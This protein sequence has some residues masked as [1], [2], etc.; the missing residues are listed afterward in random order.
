[1][2]VYDLFDELSVAACAF[3]PV[4]ESLTPSSP[5]EG[6]QYALP[7]QIWAPFALTYPRGL[8]GPYIDPMEDDH[9]TEGMA[10]GGA[11]NN[12]FARPVLA[13]GAATSSYDATDVV[14]THILHCLHPFAD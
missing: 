11:S 14:V 5:P 4:R 12:H 9:A 3:C 7:C 8:R 13:R 1:M 2:D 6:P 10:L